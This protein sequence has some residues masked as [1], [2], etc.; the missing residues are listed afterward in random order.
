MAEDACEGI[1]VG[2][3]ERFADGSADG[4]AMLPQKLTSATTTPATELNVQPLF[5]VILSLYL[6]EIDCTGGATANVTVSAED[7]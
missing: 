7:I 6:L 5:L 2:S 1:V 3:L 4:T